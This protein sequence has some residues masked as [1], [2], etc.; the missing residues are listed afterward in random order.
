MWISQRLM[1]RLLS[2]M[3]V[4]ICDCL[5]SSSSCTCKWRVSYFHVLLF[6]TLILYQIWGELSIG[7]LGKI[8]G[9]G[10]ERGEGRGGRRVAGMGHAVLGVDPIFENFLDLTCAANRPGA[11]GRKSQVLFAI[12]L[13]FFL[14]FYFGNF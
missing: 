5:G 14:K 10:E 2:G 12:F 1:R 4:L 3:L 11:A 13:N 6:F 7:E 9:K 8:E